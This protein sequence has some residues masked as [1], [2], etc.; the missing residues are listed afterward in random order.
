MG[1][2]LAG[3]DGGRGIRYGEGD[4]AADAKPLA[5]ATGGTAATMG[6]I[7]AGAAASTVAAAAALADG[8]AEA[9]EVTGK[10]AAADIYIDRGRTK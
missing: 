5:A 9:M 4:G 6:V 1:L 2:E 10:D 7:A 8:R 3:S